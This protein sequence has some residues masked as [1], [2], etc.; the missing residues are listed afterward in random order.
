[1]NPSST[2]IA[3]SRKLLTFYKTTSLYYTFNSF[4][5]RDGLP[6]IPGVQGDVGPVG[7]P[8]PPGPPGISAEAPSGGVYTRWGKNNCGA[9]STLLYK[10]K[11]YI[12]INVFISIVYIYIHINVFVY[13]YIYIYILSVVSYVKE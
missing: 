5:G 6:G 3:I 4:I 13:I 12:Q 11:L 7:P 8:G 9:D 10:G 1:V 2:K